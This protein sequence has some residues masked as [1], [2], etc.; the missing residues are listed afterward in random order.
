L[1]VDSGSVDGDYFDTM[2]EGFFE[3][4]DRPDITEFVGKYDARLSVED[5]GYGNTTD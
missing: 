4:E 2:P 3:P 1:I 5:G